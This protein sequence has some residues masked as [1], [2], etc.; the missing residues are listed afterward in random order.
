MPLSRLENFLKNVPGNVIYVNPD[1]LDATDDIN[2]TGNSRTRPFKTIQ[3]ALLESARFSYQ[4]GKDNDKFDRTSI[5][6]STGTHIID[7]RPGLQIDTAGSLTDINGIASSIAQFSVGTNFDVSDPN[8]V[9]VNFNS[10]SGGVIVPRG[11][12]II[13][14]DL[15]KTK[16]RPKFIPNPNDNSINSTAIFRVTGACFFWGFSFFDGDP[17]DTVFRDYTSNVYGSRYSHHKLTCF[18]YADG[19]NIVTGKGNTDLDM[20]Y[21][22]LTLAY[23]VNSQRALPVYPTNTD[24]EAI[25]DESRIVGAITQVGAVTITDIYSGSTPSDSTATPVVTVTTLTDHGLSVG[26]P[27]LING[28]N[29]TEYDGTF[30]TSQVLSDTSFTYTLPTTP[31]TTSTPNLSGLSPT[32]KI[33]SDTVTSASPYIF[34]C[35]IRSVFGMNGLFADGA[36]AT[37]FKSMVVA[38]FTGISLNKDD[39]VYVKYNTTSGIW[40]D[41]ATLGSS[42]SLHSD[43]LARHTPEASNYHIRVSNK[44]VIQ[45]VSV[46]AIGYKRHFFAES[47][48]DASITN[49]NSNFGE[50]AL[51]ADKFRDEAFLKDDK[52]FIVDISAPQKKFTNP[53]NFNWLTLD[54]DI[55][56]G[57]STDSKLYLFG[58]RQRDNVPPSKVLEFSVG[59][60]LNDQLSLQ[61]N[62]I[63]YDV[64]ILMPV[65]QTDPDDRVSARKEI[66]VGSNSGINSISSDRFT[67]QEN[68]KFINGESIRFYSDDGALPDGIEYN[69]IYYAITGV[70]DDKIDIAS[71]KNNAAAGSKLTGINNLGGKLKII[72]TVADKIPGDAGHPIQYDSSGWFI[73]VGV[74]N[75]LSAAIVANSTQLSPETRQTFIKRIR[76]TRDDSEKRYGLTYV[77]PEGSSLASP[78]IEGY[79]IEESSSVIDDI[80]YKNDNTEL[81]SASDLRTKTNIIN[82]DWTANVGI[83]TTQYRHGLKVGNTI[84]INRLKSSNNTAGDDNSGFNG[85]FKI[86]SVPTATSFTVGLNTDPGGITTIATNVPYTFHDQSVVGSGRTFSPYFTR[87]DFGPSYQIREVGQIQEFRKGIQDGI[88][89]LTIRGYLSTPTVSPFSTASNKFGQD[90]IDIVPQNDP[91]NINYDPEAAVSYAV[92]N[93]VGKV[94]TNNPSNSIT[95]ESLNSILENTGVGIA[96]T[97]TDIS[98]GTICTIDTGVSHGLNPISGIHSI[99]GG[100]NYGSISGVSENYFNVRLEG[101]SGEGATADI[102]VSTSSTISNVVINNPGSGYK[103]DD[104]LT[105]KGVPFHTP[106][107]DSTVGVSSI[108]EGVGSVGQIVGVG[109]TSYDG[110]YTIKTVDSSTRFTYTGIANLPSSG[111][112]FYHVGISTGVVSITHDAISGIAT[113]LLDGDIGLRRGEEIVISGCTGAS[114]IYNGTHHI[115]DRI[116]YG[117]S[118]SVN[119]GVTQSA[120]SMAGIVTAHGTGFSNRSSG[121]RIPIYGGLTTKLSSDITATASSVIFSDTA[122][123]QRG[124]FLLIEDEIVRISNSSGNKILRGILGTNAVTHSANVA[125]K[126]IKVIPIEN[127]R[128]S[129]L[130]ASGHTFEYVGYGPGNYSTAMP[131]VQDRVLTE[132]EVLLSQSVQTRGGFVVY[133]GMNDTGEFFIGSL[134]VGSKGEINFVG[135]EGGRTGEKGNTLPDSATFKDITVDNGLFDDLTVDNLKVNNNTEVKD[136]SLTGNR[137][138]TV[139]QSIFVGIANT[140]P[141]S[142]NDDILFNTLYKRGGFLGWVRTDDASNAWKRFGIISNERDTEDYGFDRLGVGVTIASDGRAFEVSGESLLTGNATVTGILTASNVTGDLTGNS[143]TASQLQTARTIS[144]TGDVSGSTTFDGSS[145]VSISASIS[146]GNASTASKLQTARTISITGDVTGSTTFDGSSNASIS[147]ALSN[148]GVSPGTYGSSS[149]IPSIT[150]AGDGRLTSVTSNSFSIGGTIPIGGIIMWSGSTA[151]SGWVLCDNSA[152]AQAAGA[153]DLRDKFVVGAGGLYGAGAQ[154]GEATK[155]LGTANLPSHTHTPGSL[156]ATG[157]NH[158]HSFSGSGSNTHSHG[159]PKGSGGAEADIS[160]YVPSPQVEYIGTPFNTDN[161]N[162]SI[163]VSGTTG[164]SGNLSLGV[165][166]NTGDQGGPM[167]QAFEILPPYFAIAYIMRIS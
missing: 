139:G 103:K 142:L 158:S 81:T 162:I 25:K 26:T 18:E 98:S 149:S 55:T 119:I 125:V 54:V 77:I 44:A 50:T 40:Q 96:I 92:R 155:T 106:G 135:G 34:N 153:P 51:E 27:I 126:K 70:G 7:N 146:G 127:R 107:S 35:S 59:N 159:I 38:Q 24:F 154:G 15:R 36:K 72:S 6:L 167:N 128:Y 143:S 52:G 117:S 166:G 120:P 93:V 12:S 1:E 164:G 80:N 2:N 118:L 20:Y 30:I 109:S 19:T 90:I 160:N 161:A 85:I 47:G 89:N 5:H 60:K 49:S 105:I 10:I 95:R 136:I 114:A 67:L 4:P 23:G 79:S 97:G 75:T 150:V 76:D 37:G 101:G 104:T 78:P 28:V 130:R 66:F 63:T 87:M 152:A 147:A 113:V 46:F 132:D 102:T 145:D 21:H 111:G 32:V 121:R 110:L 29:N 108:I 148:S 73:N 124:D 42:L 56:A 99:S 134:K 157:G 62:N 163:T 45:A 69:K 57:L 165:G 137:S 122:G 88:Y 144:I 33:E 141:T 74:G 84:K 39:S 11:T 100:T 94:E 61:I 65:P 43:S 91:D 17:N 123:L 129:V 82:A 41:Q 156:T 13:G 58:Y 31:S 71:N 68:H 14:D 8:N 53:S 48:G 140:Y 151:P 131:Q 138:G 86:D 133:T 115:S 112:F 22:K 83:V 16:I 9:L 64:S 3:R 116:G